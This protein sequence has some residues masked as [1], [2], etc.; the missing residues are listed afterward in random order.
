MVMWRGEVTTEVE[1]AQV[2]QRR[3]M[4]VMS[5][6]S[7]LIVRWAHSGWKAGFLTQRESRFLA[8]LRGSFPVDEVVYELL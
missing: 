6:L 5:G 7:C 4:T 8:N 1:R 2:F 3:G